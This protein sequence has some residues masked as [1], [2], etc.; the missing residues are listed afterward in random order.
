MAARCAAI[1]ELQTKLQKDSKNEQQIDESSLLSKL[2]GYCSKEAHSCV[3]KAAMI[4]LVKLRILDTDENFSL[5]GQSL[6]EAMDEDKRNGL[7]PFFVSATLGTTSCCSF[8]ALNEIGPICS[9]ENIWLHVDAA[10]AGNA[11]ICPEFQY[12][13]KGIEVIN[14]Q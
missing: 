5:R 2:V 8:D 1:K 10:Y 13:M 7:I 6:R 9:R 4:A 11:F 14:Y 3:E 12:L